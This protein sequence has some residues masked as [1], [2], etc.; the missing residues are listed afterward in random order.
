MKKIDENLDKLSKNN[1]AAFAAMVAQLQSGD[2]AS[3]LHN[4]AKV[5]QYQ[6]P[7]KPSSTEGKYGSLTPKQIEMIQNALKK[8]NKN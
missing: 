4:M 5:S 7:E 3:K 1:L 2:V 8:R 6:D